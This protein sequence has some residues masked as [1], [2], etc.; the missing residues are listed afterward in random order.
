MIILVAQGFNLARISLIALRRLVALC[1]SWASS[2]EERA[3]EERVPAVPVVAGALLILHSR[4][5]LVCRAQAGNTWTWW[6]LEAQSGLITLT[7][8]TGCAAA[9]STVPPT[10]LAN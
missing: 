3:A 1:L 10:G 5:R 9:A 8:M 2:W 7:T 4:R 6:I